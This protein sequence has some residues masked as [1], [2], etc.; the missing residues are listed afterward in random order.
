MLVPSS[1]VNRRLPTSSAGNVH[2]SLE[3]WLEKKLELA[4]L[5]ASNLVN[6]KL[7][8]P[9]VGDVRPSQDAS[10]DWLIVTLWLLF[11]RSSM[12]QRNLS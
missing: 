2:G 1:V 6:F 5:L 10:F 7:R 11:V 8:M 12:K 4:R 9:S 3:N